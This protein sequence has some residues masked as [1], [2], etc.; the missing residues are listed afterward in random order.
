MNGEAAWAPPNDNCETYFNLISTF[1]KDSCSINVFKLH[2][3]VLC[4][5]KLKKK[6][7]KKKSAHIVA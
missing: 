4:H 3:N 7:K 2:S 5:K 1:R 6:K